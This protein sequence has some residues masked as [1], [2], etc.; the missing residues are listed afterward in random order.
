MDWALVAFLLLV[1]GCIA[2]GITILVASW[3]FFMNSFDVWNTREN[4][5]V[6]VSG[7][8]SIFTLSGSYLVLH[9]KL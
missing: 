1:V 5:V 2:G 7:F 8:V 4:L 6:L 3:D 9:R